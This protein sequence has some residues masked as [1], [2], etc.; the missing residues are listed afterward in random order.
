MVTAIFAPL[1]AFHGV[2]HKSNIAIFRAGSSTAWIS[3]CFTILVSI[4]FPKSNISRKKKSR[5]KRIDGV[6][7]E[8]K[9]HFLNTKGKDNDKN[10][11]RVTFSMSQRIPLRVT[12]LDVLTGGIDR[13]ATGKGEAGNEK[14]VE[15]ER[16]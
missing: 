11:N 8:N 12:F 4:S 1:W 9:K 14:R 3:T 7:R 6:A 5:G 15:K 10:E 2:P 13:R 16:F